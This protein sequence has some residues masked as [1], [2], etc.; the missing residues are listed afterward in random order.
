M[1]KFQKNSFPKNKKQNDC[2]VTHESWV[3]LQLF[4][5]KYN[6]FILFAKFSF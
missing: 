6:N 4:P 2:D 1:S 3:P 5:T